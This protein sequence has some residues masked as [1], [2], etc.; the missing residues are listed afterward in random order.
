[1]MSLKL[2]VFF[3]LC[4]MKYP[5]SASDSWSLPIHNEGGKKKFK[6]IML[7]C[8]SCVQALPMCFQLK[9]N[10]HCFPNV[11]L[12]QRLLLANTNWC[13]H[14]TEDVWSADGSILSVVYNWIYK[15]IDHIRSSPHFSLNGELFLLFPQTKEG[16]F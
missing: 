10:Q 3:F 1:M 14:Q 11:G 5:L 15:Y 8:Q 4:V 13:R 2:N 9:I 7:H 6:K 12:F 16:E